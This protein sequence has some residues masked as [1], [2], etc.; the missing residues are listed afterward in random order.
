MG[1]DMDG[2]SGWGVGEGGRL[3][4][5]CVVR[6]ITVI[7]HSYS[8]ILIRQPLQLPDDPWTPA[9]SSSISGANLVARLVGWAWKPLSNWWHRRRPSVPIAAFLDYVQ[10]HVQDRDRATIDF[11][12]ILDNRT[13]K[14]WA[15]NQLEVSYWMLGHKALPGQPGWLAVDSVLGPWESGEVFK[16]IPITG[17]DVVRLVDAIE[18][19]SNPKSS[20]RAQFHLRGRIKLES[21]KVFV[22]PYRLHTQRHRSLGR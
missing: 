19:S 8:D 15:V 6:R 10:V 20:P 22:G 11:R 2:D 5:Y 7:R 16:S 17:A 9:V 1:R 4:T 3:S 12:L 21:K 13:S 18:P 14:E